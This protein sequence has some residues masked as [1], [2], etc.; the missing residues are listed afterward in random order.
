MIPQVKQRNAKLPFT[1]IALLKQV[2]LAFRTSFL[3]KT[4]PSSNISTTVHCLS[5]ARPRVAEHSSFWE[6]CAEW[7]IVSQAFHS[8]QQSDL[9]GCG[10]RSTRGCSNKQNNSAQYYEAY[11]HVT[12]F[13]KARSLSACA[14]TLIIFVWLGECHEGDLRNSIEDMC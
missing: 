8:S 7:F 11:W 6:K 9:I 2:F 5:L 14:S 12:P 4:C 10:H 3:S 1:V 13:L